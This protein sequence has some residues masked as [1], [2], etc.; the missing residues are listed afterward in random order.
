MLESPSTRSGV[1]EKQRRDSDQGLDQSTGSTSSRRSQSSRGMKEQLSR[2]APPLS[3]DNPTYDGVMSLDPL[4][5]PIDPPR[6]SLPTRSLST[7]DLSTTERSAFVGLNLTLGNGMGISD[8]F[9]LSMGEVPLGDMRSALDR[10]MEDVAEEASLGSGGSIAGRMKAEVVTQGVKTGHFESRPSA[11]QTDRHE[12]TRNVSADEGEGTME[13]DGDVNFPSGLERAPTEPVLHTAFASPPMVQRATSPV[14]PAAT[15]NARRAREELIKAKKRE[16]RRR[17]EDEDM[18]LY[19]PPRRTMMVRPSRRRSRSTG[20]AEDGSPRSSASR[21][22][23]ALSTGG[24]LDVAPF[25]DEEDPLADSI[26]RELR[27]LGSP[28]KS[29]RLIPF[30]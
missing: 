25:D 7:D 2:V 10:L 19:T 21:R 22:R 18:G 14:P 29:V 9:G 26:N 3:R 13:C 1:G 16:A 12:S 5:Q 27:K 17:E 28:S 30:P 4:P 23:A 6:P 20:D 8:D 24:L 15:T 11:Q